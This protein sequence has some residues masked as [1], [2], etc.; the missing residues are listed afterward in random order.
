[1]HVMAPRNESALAPTIAGY[2]RLQ[3]R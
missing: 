1:V 3:A 2:R